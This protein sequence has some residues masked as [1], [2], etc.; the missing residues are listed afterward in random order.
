VIL[1]EHPG[2]TKATGRTTGLYHVAILL[3][4]RVSLARTIWH[5]Y[6]LQVQFGYADH[7]VSEAF[8]LSDPDNNGL[9]L[10]R[11]RP[12]SE[13]KWQQGTVQMASDAIDFENFFAEMRGDTTWSGLPDGTRLGHMHL[14]IANLEQAQ[15]F[16]V[17]LL[18]FDLVS[19]FPGALFVSAGGYHHH[20]GMNIWNSRNAPPTPA[21]AAGL[22]Y[23]TVLLPNDEEL[24]SLVERFTAAGVSFEQSDHQITIHDPWNNQLRII[25]VQA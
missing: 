4:D 13:W 7:L 9:E 17:D 5:L 2:A 8:Y 15:A 6:E 25:V 10:Y 16:Y 18:G 20:I 22:E 14:Q 21:T 24:K 12:R 19:R 1:N 11:D 23:F 3:P